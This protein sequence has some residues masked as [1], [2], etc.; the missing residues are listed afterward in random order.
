MF[1]YCRNNPVCRKDISGTTSV[2]IFDSD[3]NPLTDDDQRIDGGKMGDSGNGTNTQTVKVGGSAN[4]PDAGSQGQSDGKIETNNYA[5]TSGK[6]EVHHVVEQC[7]TKKSG[8]SKSEIQSSHNTVEQVTI[9][10]KKLAD[11][12]LQNHLNLVD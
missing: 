5:G 8:F 12:I 4:A 6:T 10:I 9:F 2:D 3:G 7:Q 11:I 1:A